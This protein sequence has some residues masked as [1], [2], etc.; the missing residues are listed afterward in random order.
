MAAMDGLVA[1]IT[2]VKHGVRTSKADGYRINVGLLSQCHCHT[3]K[4]LL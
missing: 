4:N 2:N 3:L 1:V